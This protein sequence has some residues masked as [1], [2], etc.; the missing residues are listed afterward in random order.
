MQSGYKQPKY[1]KQTKDSSSQTCLLTTKRTSALV[2]TVVDVGLFLPVGYL[3]LCYINYLNLFNQ[4]KII[5]CVL[6][7]LFKSNQMSLSADVH[8]GI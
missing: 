8:Q 3:F 1:Q 2:I 6:Y 7:K 4:H 5:K